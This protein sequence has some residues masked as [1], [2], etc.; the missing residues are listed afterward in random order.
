MNIPSVAE[1]AMLI[2]I[3]YKYWSDFRYPIVVHCSAGVGRTGTLLT[4]MKK[5]NTDENIMN[6][7]VSFRQRRFGMVQT[8]DQYKFIHTY[9]NGKNRER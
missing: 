9:F 7:V 8:K 6:I 1:I 4:I 5:R 3:I 2:D